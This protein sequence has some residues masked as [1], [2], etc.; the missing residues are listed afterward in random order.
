MQ[1][2]YAG[3]IGIFRFEAGTKENA[4]KAASSD[5]M[6]PME[7]LL[8]AERATVLSDIRNQ[9]HSADEPGNMAL[10][11]HLEAVGDWVEADLLNDTDIAMLGHEL[12]R[13][14]EIDAALARIKDGTYGMC[15]DCGE[16]IPAARLDALPAARSC[17]RCQEAYEKQRGLGRG[18]SL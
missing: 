18:Q 15:I 16:H 14:R 17:V 6:H 11:N 5:S 4:V 9:L 2:Y 1:I 13:L 7:Q 10:L 12:V 8:L 3:G